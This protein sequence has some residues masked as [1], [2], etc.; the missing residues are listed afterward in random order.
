M[1]ELCASEKDSRSNVLELSALLYLPLK[2]TSLVEEVLETKMCL[3]HGVS[4]VH[5][6]LALFVD[7]GVSISVKAP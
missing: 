4:H 3:I 2:M 6:T 7:F 1:C 5:R